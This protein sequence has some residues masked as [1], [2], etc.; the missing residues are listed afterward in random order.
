LQGGGQPLP[1]SERA[2]FEPRFGYDFSSVRIHTDAHAAEAARVAKARAFT[3]GEDVVFGAGHFAPETPAGRRLLAHELTHTVQQGAIQDHFASGG[4]Q[5]VGRIAARQTV[6]AVQRNNEEPEVTV[7]SPVFEETVTQIS[8]LEA[9]IHGR[10]LTHRERTLARPI[11]GNSIDYSRVRIIP[12]RV[13]QYRTVANTIRV[14][15]DF[16]VADPEV[17][18]VFIHEM[19]H[20]WQYQHQ[21]TSYLSIS[22]VDQISAMITAS[23]R[24]FAYDYRIDSVRSFFD[25]SPEQQGFLVENYFGML[26][27]QANPCNDRTC[28]SNH[29]RSDGFRLP[30]TWADRSTEINREL[31]LHEPVIRQMRTALPRSQSDLLNLRASEVMGQPFQELVPQE[32][33]LTP[34]RPLLEVRF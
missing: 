3:V 30:I 28:R 16:D 9:A 24:N 21:G 34:L 10:P 11:F 22:L 27:D 31:P 29:L 12:T 14:P 32:Q 18:Q 6:P 25:L 23:N 17:A 13:L 1:R 8:S 7:R 33:H 20:V 5:P 4:P 15:P 19:T 2:F 26:R